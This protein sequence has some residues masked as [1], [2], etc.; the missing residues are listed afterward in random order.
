MIDNAKRNPLICPIHSDLSLIVQHVC[1]P[2]SSLTHR[3]PTHTH[4]PAEV[5]R[6]YASRLRSKLKIWPSGKGGLAA[7]MKL[8]HAHL[9]PPKGTKHTPSNSE[10]AQNICPSSKHLNDRFVIVSNAVF[11]FETAHSSWELLSISRSQRKKDLV[12]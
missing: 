7:R 12:I 1:Q 6:G 11:Q 2:L 8:L 5:Y 4:M 9:L 3:P 10:R